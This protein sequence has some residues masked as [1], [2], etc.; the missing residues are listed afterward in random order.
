MK[1]ERKKIERLITIEAS[2]SG[3]AKTGRSIFNFRK[4]KL[5]LLLLTAAGFINVLGVRIFV[6]EK[7]KS[8]SIAFTHSPT[9]PHRPQYRKNATYEW[10]LPTIHQNGLRNGN[11]LEHSRRYATPVLEHLSQDGKRSATLRQTPPRVAV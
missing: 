4:K 3:H 10:L 8:R 5:K 1:K 9:A 11:K 7:F 6:K 2:I